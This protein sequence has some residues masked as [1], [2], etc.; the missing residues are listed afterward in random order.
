MKWLKIVVVPQSKPWSNATL[1]RLHKLSPWPDPGQLVLHLAMNLGGH[2]QILWC[3]KL[4]PLLKKKSD[5][6]FSTWLCGTQESQP[7]NNILKPTWGLSCHILSANDARPNRPNTEPS[8]GIYRC[9][10]SMILGKSQKSSSSKFYFPIDWTNRRLAGL[11]V[12]KS[13][14]VLKLKDPESAHSTFRSGL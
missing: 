13:P 11:Q 3:E 14:K 7:A 1:H 9:I 6:H 12:Q 10:S 2:G 4:V 5:T 8:W